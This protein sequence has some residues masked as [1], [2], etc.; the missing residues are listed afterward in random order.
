MS[1]EPNRLSADQYR[2]TRLRHYVKPASGV[3]NAR[4]TTYRSVDPYT[5][6]PWAVVPDGGSADVDQAVEAARHA[7]HGE[8]GTMS[9]S[10]RAALMRALATLVSQEA[11]TLAQLETRDSGKVLREARMQV[12]ALPEWLDY[13]AGFADKLRGD[14]ISVNNSNIFAY[15]RRDP[16]G[17][18]GAVVPWNSPLLLTVSKMAP[19]LAAG[20][21]LVIKPSEHTPVTALELAALAGKAG[22]PKGVINVVTSASSSTG[23]ALVGHKH[24]GKIAFTG[25]TRVGASVLRSVADNF[26]RVALELGGKSAQIVFDDADLDAAANGVIAGIFAASG[27]SCMAGSRLLVQRSIHDDLV[28][29]IMSSSSNIRLGDPMDDATDM[30]PLANTDQ[31]EK[32]QRYVASAVDEG[33]IAVECGTSRPP[34]GWFIRPTILT[35]VT[36]TM[37][38]WREEIFG[39]VLS[40][41]PFDTEDEA[42]ALANDTKYGLA[43]G[44]WSSDIHRCHRVAHRLQAGTVWLNAYRVCAPAVPFGG[45]KASGV[46]RE[47]G[48]EGVLEYTETKAVWVELSGAVRDPF[49]WGG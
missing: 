31:Y 2:D 23:K 45:F 28:A 39:P 43:A 41:V 17:V 13:Y 14:S 12:R 44:V 34:N 24:V 27:Q 5:Q 6:A 48:I 9:G 18:V 37:T 42:V 33:A 22:F 40:V 46:G 3:H 36:P 38:V 7:F 35:E 10:G 16:V 15:T 21:T 49:K 26:T 29:R 25:S 19:A 1:H 20:C 47:N 30:G 32:V 8:W 11:E 4:G